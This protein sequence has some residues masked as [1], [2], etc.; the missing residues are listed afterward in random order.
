MSTVHRTSDAKTNTREQEVFDD[1][2][3]TRGSD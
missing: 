2:R 1:I 3:A